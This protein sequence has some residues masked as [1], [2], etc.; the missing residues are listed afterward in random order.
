MKKVTQH[1]GIFYQLYKART[2]NPEEYIPIWK[3]I[4]EVWVEEVRLWAFISYEVSARMSELYSENP[5]LFEREQVTG[6]TGA[7]Y[8]AYRIR[9]G[10]SED[11]IVE[12]D[13]KKFYN[14]IKTKK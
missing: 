13:L 6:K 12:P 1:Q 10:V 7:R 2:A 9:I 14:L 8:Y 3:L 11:D 5:T 4:G